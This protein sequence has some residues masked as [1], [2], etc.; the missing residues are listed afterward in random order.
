M[1]KENKG[2]FY[3]EF[4]MYANKSGNGHSTTVTPF[5]LEQ[6]ANLKEGDRIFLKELDQEAKNKII[7]GAQRNG[8]EDARA[9]DYKIVIL[10]KN[11]ETAPQLPKYQPKAKTAKQPEADD[12]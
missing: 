4:S 3:P 2:N 5:V 1:S 7:A 6:L 9:P 8:R 12:L 11:T 10:P